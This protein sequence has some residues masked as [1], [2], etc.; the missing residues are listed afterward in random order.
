M[1][2]TLLSHSIFLSL[3][4]GSVNVVGGNGAVH[5]KILHE[6]EARSSSVLGHRD[7]W[8]GLALVLNNHVRCLCQSRG[9]Q[10]R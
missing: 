10:R 7:G 9:T 2:T 6:H 4:Y 3:K 8:L 1:N 5:S